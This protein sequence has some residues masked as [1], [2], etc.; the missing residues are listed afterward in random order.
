MNFALYE[1]ENQNTVDTLFG[2]IEFNKFKQ[3][4]LDIKRGE[5]KVKQDG[6][7]QVVCGQYDEKLFWQ[8]YNEKVD[9]SSKKWQQRIQHSEDKFDV[10]MYSR[11][12]ENGLHMNKSEIHYKGIKLET[13]LEF[14]K[15][16]N[17]YQ[18]NQQHIKKM[19]ILE[20]D[21]EGYPTKVY[22]VMKMG[23]MTDRES[24]I[25][26]DMKKQSDGKYLWICQSYLDPAYPIT[27]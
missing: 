27:D 26:L 25:K 18:D 5:I 1:K 7:A 19:D 23:F 10:T 22:S 3:Q 24:L 17:K 11:P 2:F 14:F 12:Q 4:V 6:S 20:N 8:L 21:S 13:L 9:D 15:N 16:F